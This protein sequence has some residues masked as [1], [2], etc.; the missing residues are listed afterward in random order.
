MLNSVHLVNVLILLN[1]FI[2]LLM[3]NIFVADCAFNPNVMD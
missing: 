1:I 2:G 3:T